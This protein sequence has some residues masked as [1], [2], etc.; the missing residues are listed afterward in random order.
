M[1]KLITVNHYG[2]YCPQ[3]DT[4]IDPWRAVGRAIIT[5]AHGDHAKKG[6][7]KYLSSK[8]S[9]KLLRLRLG[10]K[11]NLQALDWNESVSIN[12]VKISFHPSGH[13]LGSAQV[14]LEY[15]G[16]IVVISGDYKLD[17]DPTCD[18]FESIK[19]HTFITESTFGL[20]I[21]KWEESSKIFNE[22]H[23][24]WRENI[25]AGKTSVVFAY[26]LGKAQRVLAEIDHSIGPTA[27]HGSI[28]DINRIYREEG[29]PLPDPLKANATNMEFIRKK[30]LVIAPPSTSNTSWLRKLSPYT[31]VFISGWSQ[32]NDTKDQPYARKGFPISDHAD[33][34]GLNYAVKAS[35][36]ENILV[37]HGHTA[38]FTKWLNELGYNAS[39][40]KTNNNVAIS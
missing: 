20:P 34:D 39:V 14:R 24:W 38:E 23:Q 36:A 33:W 16:E 25:E 17:A 12:G 4:Y 7:R 15:D 40:L 2:I 22:L 10:E 31:S 9:E 28:L 30:T 6:S 37:T 19:C 18:P 32:T 13:I 29:I 8:R 27:V 11:I 26:A 21:Y 5:H 35:G 3:A 1:S